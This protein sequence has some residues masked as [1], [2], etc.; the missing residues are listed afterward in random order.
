MLEHSRQEVVFLTNKVSANIF[1]L[2]VVCYAQTHVVHL[3]LR[4][5]KM[6]IYS[7]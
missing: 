6:S 4:N 3:D 2:D 5:L 7:P 1:L